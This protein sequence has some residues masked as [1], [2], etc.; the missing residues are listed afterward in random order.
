MS[1][2]YNINFH[3][4]LSALY[5][6]QVVHFFYLFITC[7]PTS[8]AREKNSY[9]WCLCSLAFAGDCQGSRPIL[10]CLN[11]HLW[12]TVAGKFALLPQLLQ[13]SPTDG[14]QYQPEYVCEKP[15]NLKTNF[16]L[17]ST[18]THIHT[19]INMYLAWRVLVGNHKYFGIVNTQK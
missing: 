4:C 13:R 14:A 11:R 19:C 16:F 8:M 6:Q 9:L 18:H 3:P 1:S 2:A 10:I 7:I 12:D 5:V 17:A 15:R